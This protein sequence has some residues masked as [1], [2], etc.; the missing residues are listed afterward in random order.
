MYTCTC[1]VHVPRTVGYVYPVVCTPY[2]V[3]HVP[4]TVEYTYQL[5][6]ACVSHSTVYLYLT[7]LGICIP[8]YEVHSMVAFRGGKGGP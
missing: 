7:V 1:S 4:C 3:M 6:E 2:I 5:L 8:H